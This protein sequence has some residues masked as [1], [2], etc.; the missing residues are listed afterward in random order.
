MLY[1]RQ[2]W[3]Y[4]F[5]I[6][7][8]SYE[9]AF[10]YTYDEVTTR[11][12]SNATRRRE[13]SGCHSASLSDSGCRLAAST[14]KRRTKAGWSSVPYMK[15]LPLVIADIGTYGH[16]N[17]REMQWTSNVSVIM[18][19]SL[20]NN[21]LHSMYHGDALLNTMLPL[22]VVW[23]STRAHLTTQQLRQLHPQTL[24]LVIRGH[25]YPHPRASGMNSQRKELQSGRL[26][27][28][29]IEQFFLILH[30]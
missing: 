6:N 25:S 28:S 12:S 14:Y 5:S 16:R 3:L 13:C 15:C 1:M 2:V 23:R 4:V 21:N 30:L 11:K 9:K 24:L 17:V 29:E 27:A 22:L 8:F 18:L 10:Q 26:H 20:F 19:F 7:I